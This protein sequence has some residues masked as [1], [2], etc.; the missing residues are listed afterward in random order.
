M[1]K[2]ILLRGDYHAE[3]KESIFSIDESKR[4]LRLRNT[5]HHPSNSSHTIRANDMKY[6][7]KRKDTRPTEQSTN[8]SRNNF[9]K[10]SR[11]FI[12]RFNR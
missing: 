10:E 3:A 6:V 9:F 11:Y 4:N 7:E 5:R 2:V 8:V 1:L 12:L